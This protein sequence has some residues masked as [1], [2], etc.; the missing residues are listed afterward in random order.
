M[1]I[2]DQLEFAGKVIAIAT[3]LLSA[4]RASLAYAKDRSLQRKKSGVL[5]NVDTCVK[6]LTRI[7][8]NS[9]LLQFG[10]LSDGYIQQVSQE[11]EV[12]LKQLESIRQEE[13]QRELRRTQDPKGLRKVLSLYKPEGLNGWISQSLFYLFAL[14]G[15]MMVGF[16]IALASLGPRADRL[17]SLIA[18]PVSLM[19]F[20][21]AGYFENV[22][23]RLK[24]IGNAQ[25]RGELSQECNSDLGLLQKNLLMV[26]WPSWKSNLSRIFYY[27]FVLDAIA[28]PLN[29][30]Q[31][32]GLSPRERCLGGAG[33]LLVAL[34]LRIDVLSRR[35]AAQIKKTV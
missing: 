29:L 23:L 9:D 5:K 8:G 19:Y 7:R 18:L 17:T 12:S 16:G 27:I 34:V 30:V 24:L 22:S 35:A 1:L 14:L 10:A 26:G 32:N 11:I 6:R 13:A 25:R 31:D 15:L 28:V 21:I 3:P 2:K 4:L 33:C 20:V